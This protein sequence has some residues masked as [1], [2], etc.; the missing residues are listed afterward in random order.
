MSIIVIALGAQ[1]SAAVKRITPEELAAFEAF[2]PGKSQFAYGNVGVASG[3]MMLLSTLVMYVESVRHRVSIMLTG[4]SFSFL[5]DFLGAAWPILAELFWFSECL[6]RHLVEVRFLSDHT[7]AVL[8]V[9]FAVT[10]GLA[11]KEANFFASN[12]GQLA[13]GCD[14]FESNL[15]TVCH[16]A[17]PL[18]IVAIMTMALCESR[19]TPAS[20]PIEQDGLTSAC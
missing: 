11:L 1:T 15:G 6:S 7:L 17:Q 2:N 9:L 12:V 3:V 5:C 13:K 20:T 4:S 16:E 10:G 19:N 14:E 18:G 8:W